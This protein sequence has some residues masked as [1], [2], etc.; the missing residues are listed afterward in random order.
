MNKGYIILLLVLLTNANSQEFP[1]DRWLQLVDSKLNENINI[2]FNKMLKDA[3]AA[4]S[5]NL[6]FDIDNKILSIHVEIIDSSFNAQGAE[7]FKQ[8]DLQQFYKS[9]WSMIYSVE[10]YNNGNKTRINYTKIKQVQFKILK[11]K[12]KIADASDLDLY[13]KQLLIYSIYDV[14]KDPY[15]IEYVNEYSK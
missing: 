1:T 15:R 2:N 4:P 13:N 5:F 6:S 10:V 9:I 12:Y 7:D 11:T 14:K 3:I 8:K